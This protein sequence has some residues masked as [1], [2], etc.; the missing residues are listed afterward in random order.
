VGGEKQAELFKDIVWEQMS[1]IE[2]QERDFVFVE[3]EIFE[4]HT[5]ASDHLGAGEGRLVTEGSQEI[6]VETGETEVGAGEVND[7]ET[8]GVKRGSE[9]SQ[10][11]RLSTAGIASHQTHAALFG[12]VIET[13]AQ[14]SLSIG[15]E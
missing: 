8:V 1:F 12:Q 6:A 14:F 9:T 7:K 5:D 15:G 10:S 4:R 11:R 3:E 13:G 2:D